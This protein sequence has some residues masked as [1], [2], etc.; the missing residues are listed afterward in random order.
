MAESEE[1]VNLVAECGCGWVARGEEN[2]VVEAM[3]VHRRLIHDTEI[4][5]E[6]VLAAAKRA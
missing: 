2:D 6:E 4:T 5:R 3:Q 1:D